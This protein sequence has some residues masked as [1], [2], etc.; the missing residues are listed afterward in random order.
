[1][2]RFAAARAPGT[3]H[4][5]TGLGCQ[6]DLACAIAAD[7][8]FVA[9][10]ADGAGSAS[11]AEVGARTA[12]QVVVGFVQKAL[13]Q[14]EHEP[15][16]MLRNAAQEARNRLADLAREHGTEL[17]ELACTLLAVI[18]GPQTGAALQIGDGVI[19][20]GRDGSDWGWVFWPQR[21]E[22]ANTTHFLTDEDAASF[23]RVEELNEPFSEV[24]L[25]TD[26]LE[27]LAL[28]YATT[29]AYRPFFEAIFKPLHHTDGEGKIESLSIELEKFLVSEAVRER[30]DDDVS[31][32]IG[33]RRP[34]GS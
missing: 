24:A 2:W 21:G 28:H 6:D 5:K 4:L 13:E 34:V 32:I 12:V 22:F 33:T 20:L 17:R 23:L 16:R 27:R 30:T 11:M 31:L 10:V 19:V 15:V 18:V 29:S 1:V 3:S 9:A 8:T 26:G 7:G 14:R 25:M